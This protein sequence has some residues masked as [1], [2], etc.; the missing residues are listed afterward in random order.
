MP[1]KA[2]NRANNDVSSPALAAGG[3][4]SARQRKAPG[5]H[6]RVLSAVHSLV[7]GT[8][9]SKSASGGNIRRNKYIPADRPTS[10]APARKPCTQH[11]A[12]HPP[13]R[14]HINPRPDT[15]AP[16]HPLN[17]AKSNVVEEL[18]YDQYLSAL[19]FEEDPPE[20]VFQKQASLPENGIDQQPQKASKGSPGFADE[21]LEDP[22][23]RENIMNDL[24]IERELKEADL[25][26]YHA[27]LRASLRKVALALHSNN[28]EENQV[29]RE[30]WK[31]MAQFL[32]QKL[33][34]NNLNP[35]LPQGVPAAAETQPAE[36]ARE[37]GG[38]LAWSF[39]ISPSLSLPSPSEYYNLD[40]Y[41]QPQQ[42]QQLN[43]QQQQRFKW[44]G[45][46]EADAFM[47]VRLF[48][49]KGS[50]EHIALHRQTDKGGNGSDG[51]SPLLSLNSADFDLDTT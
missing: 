21:A 46:D 17:T 12:L 5:L 6:K 15:S 50:E 8:R 34:G 42:Q 22:K 11:R 19:P 24:D 37:R 18:D 31:N 3:Q 45:E 25:D 39:P 26:T 2:G 40:E 30:G 10:S 49:D 38:T 29:E 16:T 32:T 4:A 47:D 33:I 51:S 23:T 41:Q 44:E 43:Q 13:P 27:V 28:F 35:H 7:R 36:A 1:E 14:S 48:N 20:F 9:S